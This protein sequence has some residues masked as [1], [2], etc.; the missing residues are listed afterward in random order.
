MSRI[1][2]REIEEIIYRLI[3]VRDTATM[4]RMNVGTVEETE[5]IKELTEKWRN[6]WLVTPLDEIIKTLKWEM[7]R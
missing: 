2:K 5:K 1:R 3:E 4:K 7:N 6:T